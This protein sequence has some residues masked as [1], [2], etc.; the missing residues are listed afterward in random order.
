LTRKARITKLVDGEQKEF[1]IS[2]DE[3]KHGD[4]LGRG[5]FGTVRKMFHPP[6][7][8][9]FA[10]KMI[11]DDL[12]ESSSDKQNAEIMDLEVPLRM[13]DGC[14]YLI[15]FYGALHAEAY[16]WIL[17]E[18]MDTSLDRFYSKVFALTVPMP[19]LF[20]S[21]VAFSVVTALDFMRNLK[22]M[23]RDIKPSNILLNA[24]G[25]IKGCRLTNKTIFI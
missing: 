21:K 24:T 1:E 25:E 10:V 18:V 16:I 3:L 15:K 19:Q 22:L 20:L 8:L 17:T 9:T 6:S 4:L 12:M 2:Y 14:P 23:H 7:E 5:Q 13:G 11:N